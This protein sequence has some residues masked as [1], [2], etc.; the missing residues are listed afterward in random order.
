MESSY[1]DENEQELVEISIN[2]QGID[3]A[4]VV[5][6]EEANILLNGKFHF[7]LISH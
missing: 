5:S 6:F 7:K 1:S 2:H 3:V 4:A